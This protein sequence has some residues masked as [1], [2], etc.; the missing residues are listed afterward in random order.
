VPIVSVFMSS[1]GRPAAL[2]AARIPVFAFPEAAARAMGRVATYAGWRHRPLG[3]VV[4]PDGLDR[5]RARTLVDEALLG[6]DEGRWL[7]TDEASAILDAYG[8]RQARS[9]IVTTADEG[10]AIQRDWS[11]PVAVKVASALHKADVGGIVLGLDSGAAVAEA[12][13]AIEGS[14]ASHD[15]SSHAGRY[16]VQE[17]VTGGVEMVV[18]VRHDPSFGPIV[19][20]GM[21]GTLVELLRDVSVRITPLTDRD[22]REMLEGLRMA[23][24]LRGYRGS[25]PADVAA[26]ED[27]L[28]RVNAMVEDLPE[29]AELDLNPVFVLPAG[30]G[31]VCVDVRMRLAPARTR[32][33]R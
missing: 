15:L 11:V 12:I 2:A 30:E 25:P 32:T 27:L 8:V 17:M 9:A 16:L 31:A 18:G 19:V 1:T 20:T 7:A 24:L 10:S 29:I 4:E 3:D 23:P 28:H 14:L 33:R 21:G 13:L 22:V 6:D 26:L 5:D